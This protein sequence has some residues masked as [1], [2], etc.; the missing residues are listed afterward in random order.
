M[1]TLLDL[2]LEIREIVFSYIILS[3]R[4]APQYSDARN[5]SRAPLEDLGFNYSHHSGTPECVRHA[6]VY[7][8]HP[9]D[10]LLQVNY[11]LG[12]ESKAVWRRLNR[13]PVDCYLDVM[14]AN[15]AEFWPSFLSV[16]NPSTQLDTVYARVHGA[17]ILDHLEHHISTY[18]EDNR[19]YFMLPEVF[20]Q[21]LRTGPLLE[22][23]ARAKWIDDE[24]SDEPPWFFE[25]DDLDIYCLGGHPFA[26]F[27]IDRFVTVSALV[28]DFIAPEK[29]SRLPSTRRKKEKFKRIYSWFLKHFEPDLEYFFP[30]DSAIMFFER[31]GKIQI[32]FEGVPQHEINLGENLASLRSPDHYRRRNNPQSW[33]ERI[34]GIIQKRRERGFPVVVVGE[35]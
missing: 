16:Y 17:G 4:P 29:D 28:I 31:I 30:R 25:K 1:A 15:E 22:R 24:L 11:Q 27:P 2:P 33:D 6:T 9:A 21:F 8:S 19:C 13:F 14:F 10:A 20:L 7:E 32:C 26:E 23:D 12:R 5:S 34:D 18:S 3:N 35:S